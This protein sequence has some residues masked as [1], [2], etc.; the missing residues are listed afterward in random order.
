MSKQLNFEI[1]DPQFSRQISPQNELAI[2]LGVNS[3]SYLITNPQGQLLVLR[4]YQLTDNPELAEYAEIVAQDV[5]LQSAYRKTRLA[6]MSPHFTLV[7]TRLYNAA[8]KRTYLQEVY[9][10]AYE[11]DVQADEIPTAQVQLVYAVPQS[12]T[13]IVQRQLFGGQLYHAVTAFLTGLLHRVGAPV[14]PALYVQV[15]PGWLVAALLEGKSLLF[16]NTFHYQNTKDFLYF[17]LLILDQYKLAPEDTPVYLSGHIIEQSEIYPLLRRYIRS[18]QFLPPP[19][20]LQSGNQWQQQ[21]SYFYFNL[22]S[23]TQ[24]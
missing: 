3:L 14:S 15:H 21:P 5:H 23:L 22:F 16:V 6:A 9:N 20:F 19:Q 24:L 2:L 18:V 8:E 7:P 1:I 13:A 10:L 4:D 11:K 17:V 12:I